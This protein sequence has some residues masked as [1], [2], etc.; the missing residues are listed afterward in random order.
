MSRNTT[1][2]TIISCSRRIADWRAERI[3]HIIHGSRTAGLAIPSGRPPASYTLAEASLSDVVWP[4]FAHNPW[5]A[6]PLM[7]DEGCFPFSLR[8]EPDRSQW[9]EGAQGIGYASD[10]SPNQRG[11]DPG[12][13]PAPPGGAHRRLRT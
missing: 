6:P 5:A 8:Y 7:G 10:R 1:D 13:Y 3:A 9:N 12:P 4:K 11:V 2:A